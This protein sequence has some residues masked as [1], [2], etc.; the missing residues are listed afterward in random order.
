MIT[1]SLQVISVNEI[2]NKIYE[3]SHALTI[4]KSILNNNFK[5]PCW[6]L[7]HINFRVHPLISTA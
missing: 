3:T 7:K 1:F 2:I 6:F 4:L 5:K